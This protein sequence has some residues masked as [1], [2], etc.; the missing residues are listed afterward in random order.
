MTLEQLLKRI[1]R[2][3]AAAGSQDAWSRQIGVPASMVSFV[4][5]GRIAPPPKLL[6]AMGLERIVT[7]REK[8]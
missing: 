2:E 3:I 5:N 1:A 4:R 6:D 7:Y 8:K